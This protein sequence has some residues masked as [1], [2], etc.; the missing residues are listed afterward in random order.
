MGDIIGS[1]L[2]PK[3]SGPSDEEVKAKEAQESRQILAAATAT[4]TRRSLRL[5]TSSLTSTPTST[6]LNIPGGGT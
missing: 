4:R 5:G 1:L 3:S 2:G 6:G